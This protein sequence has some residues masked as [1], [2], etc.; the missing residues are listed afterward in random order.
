MDETG[1]REI[2]RADSVQADEHT[3]AVFVNKFHILV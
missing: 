2:R 1:I 3:R